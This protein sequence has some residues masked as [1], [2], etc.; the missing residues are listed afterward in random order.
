[1]WAPVPGGMKDY[2][3]TP[4]TNGYQSLHTVVLPLG[5]RKLFPLE[6]Q[7][8]TEEMQRYAEYGIAGENWVAASKVIDFL[9]QAQSQQLTGET[10]ESVNGSSSNGS[11]TNGSV[12]TTENSNGN[13]L[14][15]GTPQGAVGAGNGVVNGKV[16]GKVNGVAHINGVRIEGG[17]QGTV[18][19]DVDGDAVFKVCFCVFYG[20]FWCVLCFVGCC[21]SS[22][23]L[24]G[25]T[26]DATI[27]THMHI[28]MLHI[29]TYTPTP[30]T[31]T[32]LHTQPPTKIQAA[33]QHNSKVEQQ[34]LMRRVNWLNSIREWQEEFLGS[35]TAREFVD[36]VTDDLLSQ[37]V[38]VFTPRGEVMRLP[39]VCVGVFCCVLVYV[40]C[41]L[42][43]TPAHTRTLAHSPLLL[44]TQGATVVDFAYHVHT[45]VGNQMAYAKVNNQPVHASHVLQNAEV[46]EVITYDGPVTV[47]TV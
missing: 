8:R 25:L 20:V 18:M 10:L 44:S 15:N 13:G 46:V 35:L 41:V 40:G 24:P 9:E 3:A 4:K 45:D 38:F 28:L 22:H 23:I 36:C 7:I 12:G 27:T 11:S 1:M 47:S 34:L 39:K 19:R 17:L 2:I 31:H 26:C 6:V 32:P 16:N 29:R 5:S 33:V 30:S 42:F 43:Y 21:A 14:A 37:G